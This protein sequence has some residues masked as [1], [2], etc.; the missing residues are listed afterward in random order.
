[1]RV[2]SI[3]LTWFVLL[4]SILGGAPAGG[5]DLVINELMASNAGT[6]QDESGD[7]DD[8]IEI[9]NPGDQAVD[10]G[11]MYVTDRL[12]NPTKWRIPDGAAGETTI[13]A[14]GY[15]LIWADGET[16]EGTLHASFRLS[17]GG[18]AVGLYGAGGGSVDSVEFG[19]QMADQSYGRFPDGADSWESFSEPTPGAGNRQDHPDV[20]INEI[21]YHP[22]AEEF[23][24]EPIGEEYIELLN[25]GAS[26]V[27]LRGW[28]FTEG[29]DFDFPDVAVGPGEYL[30]VAADVDAFAARYPGVSHAIGGWGGQL[31]NAGETIEVRTEGDVV[32]DSVR[33]A[34]DGD[35]AVR[36]L[37][38]M[39][40]SHRGW[41][42][43]DD[44]DG[45]GRSLELIDAALANEYGQNWSA[46]DAEGGTPGA[47]NSVAATGTLPLI[48]EVAH[49]PVVPGPDDAVT[50]TAR[51]AGSSKAS[52]DVYVR[53]RVDRS[54]YVDWYSYP[55]FNAADYAT[56]L[57]YDDGAH[58]DGAARD[59]LYGAEIPPQADGAVIEFYVEV[60]DAAG[61]SRTWPAPAVVEGE[62]RQ[63]TNALYRVDAQFDPYAYWQIGSEPL[64]YMVMTE[65][66]RGRLARLGS[67]SSEAYSRA[68]MNGTFISVDGQDILLRYNVGIRNRGHGSRTPPPNNY[69]VS[70]PKDRL[71]KGRSAIILNSRYTYVQLLGHAV[72]RMAG[73]PA[74]D[75]KR[76]QVRVNGED[77]AL[78]DPERMYGSYVHVEVYD[79]DWASRQFPDDSEGNVYRCVSN[80]RAGDLRYR[81]EDPSDYRQGDSYVKN[82]NSAENDWS[83]LIALTYALDASS[84]VTY[85]Q[86]V[87]AVVNVDQWLRWFALMALMTNRETN[88]SRGYGDDYCMYRGAED[89][90]FVLLPYDL[91]SVLGPS[92]ANTSIWLEG[93][94]DSLPVV[95]RFLTHPDFVRRYYAQLHELAETV[96]A[97]ERFGPLVEQVL[98]GWVPQQRIDAFKAFAAARR[99]YVFSVIPDGLSVEADLRVADGYFARTMPYVSEMDV[100]GQADAIST[101]SVLVNGEPAELFGWE[102][103]WM[104]GE[105]R[106]DLFPGINRIIVEAFDG[107]AGTGNRLD[108]A[109]VDIH[110]RTISTNDYPRGSGGGGSGSELHG[111]EVW[112]ASEGPYR[113]RADLVV[114]AGATLT[115]GAGTTVFFDP[116]VT[117]FVRGRLLAEGTEYA[118]LRFTRTPELGGVWGGLQFVDSAEESR[119]C[120]AVIEY[121]RSDD[122]MVGLEN[123][124]LV[125]DHVTFD[126]TESRRVGAV[127]SSLVVRD[128]HFVDV[129]ESVFGADS[130]EHIWCGGATEAVVVVENNVF[131]ATGGRSATIALEADAHIE[132]NVFAH[133]GEGQFSVI[134]AGGGGD[135]VV[136]RN[137]FGGVERVAQMGDGAFMR[138]ENNTVVDVGAA[139]FAFDAV[140]GAVG[141]GGV[142]A[143]SCVFWRC[144]ELAGN[145]AGIVLNRCLAPRAWHGLG[146]GNMDVDPLFVGS[147][148]FHLRSISAARG[149]GAGGLDMGAYVPGGASVSGEPAGRTHRREA[150]LGVWGPGVTHYRY[151]VNDPD[152]PWSDERS[153]DVPIALA[154]L[155][156]GGS[157]TVYVVGKNS[158]GVWQDAPNAS[159]RWT[160]DV[161][162]RRLVL[163]EVVAASEADGT[164]ADGVELYY[165]GAA[166]MSLGGMRISDDPEQPDKF[167]FP[168]GA[169]IDPGEYLVVGSEGGGAGSGLELGFGLGAAGDAIYLYDRDGALLDSVAF[170]RQ[171][172]GLSIGRIGP[173]GDW[174][175]TAPTLGQANLA[176]PLGD[177]DGVKVNEWLA[178]A[179]VLFVEDLIELYNPH[180][181]P[182]DIGGF[183][184]TDNPATQPGKH[185]LPPLSFIEGEGF[186][187]FQ[188]DDANDRGHVGFRLSVDGEMIGLSDRDGEAVDRIIF[189]PQTPD[190]SQG[191]APDGA[192]RLDWLALPTP[193]V[194][195]PVIGDPVIVRIPLASEDAEK[196]V[197]VPLSAD[198]VDVNWNV[199]PA[200]DDSDWLVATG[201]VGYDLGSGDYRAFIDFD[202]GAQM[203]NVHPSCFVRIPFVADASSMARLE[204]LLLSVR[205]DDAFVAYLNGVEVVRANFTGTPQW[206]SLADRSHE[207]VAQEFDAVF[208]LSPYA[209]LVREGTNLLAIQAMNGSVSS[210]DLLISVALETTVVE[211]AGGEHPYL[212]ELQLLDGLRIT[213]LMYHAEAGND[214]DYIELRNIG[215][216][217]LDVTGL[218]FTD[219]IAFTFGEMMLGA[220][221]H[222][223]VVGDL[224]GFQAAYGSAA[225]VAGEY[226][227]R[228]SD[229]GEDIVL[230]LAAP[231]DAA[232]MRFRY[233]DSWYPDTD[234]DGQSL[235]VEEVT[236]AP[237]A[238]ND[239]AN[240][241]A[242]PP[243][244]GRP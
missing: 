48:G 197:L 71:W 77:P 40:Y 194:A 223:V 149:A 134:S 6:V 112:T 243:S 50:I 96:L 124:G 84:G 79:S 128:C 234:G 107:P 120:H 199:D 182:V 89:V 148:D 125:L 171:L 20:V 138:F 218:R 60:R 181:S 105:T 78:I 102:G 95:R 122:G 166:A 29:V 81:G 86:D 240:W 130:G 241:R 200:F 52:W 141:G 186:A 151:S 161:A 176:E 13:P 137:L 150:T 103:Q 38:P 44:H 2:S 170:G 28:R 147:D 82:T 119:I 110:C 37:G 143:D 109:Y 229:R 92:D 184:V 236:A 5:Q 228:L 70:F 135:Y 221:E 98:G 53:Y 146:E 188:A 230:K 165:D 121:G 183:R 97:P 235:V 169:A 155:A 66:E 142:W 180:V 18:E 157:Y 185:E 69:H 42:W 174:R 140:G 210:S 211:F 75:A 219:G 12:T 233:E 43:R 24:P 115:I 65:M 90:R 68:R 49:R 222:V 62:S 196:R 99:A 34:D 198:Q 1:M 54:V 214:G 156:D 212:K 47:A 45:G 225:T 27:S 145:P 88:L 85:V 192:D 168:V 139:A 244:P 55:Q 216:E 187:V 26:A 153:V 19:P 158:A 202:I 93:R 123:S 232:V 237:V 23:E 204:A 57:M 163:N 87:E 226:T 159:R 113:V 191:R 3:V 9:H 31:R 33:Y 131:G 206:D 129:G 11:G 154:D 172:P 83:D 59:G 101:R 16:D 215:D 173:D 35:W 162:H 17:E 118:P 7:Y 73:L 117:M 56:V 10:I 30:V 104:L 195:N 41:V 21:M 127:D 238:W 32:V 80:A 106:L 217:T 207:S 178:G 76:V 201:G 116:G 208:D 14:G 51:V 227:D 136:V 67:Q 36:E 22:Y 193:G 177:P 94:L 160:V 213:E 111:S 144:P 91:D 58:G 242:S 4:V 220:G 114:P 179:E 15:L 61:R 224:A 39:D 239:R 231:W 133:Q 100:H 152:G 46:S 132:G 64:Y 205:Y 126:N 108:R 25:R 175:L 164:P 8:W 209:G 203:Y 189:G 190:V 72:F 63:V 74:L 167:V